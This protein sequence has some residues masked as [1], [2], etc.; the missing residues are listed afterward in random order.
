MDVLDWSPVDLVRATKQTI[1]GDTQ[2]ARQ[3]DMNTQLLLMVV[4]SVRSIEAFSP[5]I[6]E[7]LPIH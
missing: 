1:R 6:E 4:L 7:R 3:T 2:P 5:A